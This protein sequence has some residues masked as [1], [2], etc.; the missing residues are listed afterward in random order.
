MGSDVAEAQID[1][2][3]FGATSANRP[4]GSPIARMAS[5][6]RISVSIE[7]RLTFPGTDLTSASTESWSSSSAPARAMTRPVAPAAPTREAM[8]ANHV[9]SALCSAERTIRVTRSGAGG[10]I[11][12]A[13]HRRNSS[14]R[15][16][17]WFR[18][19]F[20]T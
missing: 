12:S 14:S 13:R 17:S 18:S 2:T 19:A 15:T 9:S 1:D 16:L 11:C 10:S 3:T 6:L 8:T 4:G 7:F 5:S 20:A